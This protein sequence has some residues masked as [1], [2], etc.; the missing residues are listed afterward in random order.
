[1]L[2]EDAARGV[3]QDTPQAMEAV[4]WGVT[5]SPRCGIGQVSQPVR[6]APRAEVTRPAH[7]PGLLHVLREPRSGLYYQCWR[8]DISANGAESPT[9]NGCGTDVVTTWWELGESTGTA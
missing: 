5:K 1:M 6:A 3:W 4:Y 2:G 7:A 9:D 8:R